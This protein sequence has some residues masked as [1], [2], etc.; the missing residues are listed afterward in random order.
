LARSTAHG[1][2]GLRA[3]RL[4]ALALIAAVVA[5]AGG[6]TAGA[7]TV[8][9]NVNVSKDGLDFGEAAVAVNPTNP[10]Q[11]FVSGTTGLYRYSTDGGSTWAT[12]STGPAPASDGGDTSLG[13]DT[14]GN[15]FLVILDRGVYTMP[16]TGHVL[17]FISTDGGNNF[18]QIATLGTGV[19]SGNIDQPSVAVGAGEV[20]VCWRGAD[21]KIQASGAN[22]TGS[23]SGSVGSFTAPE[24]A[25]SGNFGDIAIGPTGAVMVTY[26]R[27][28]SA[29]TAS[30][31][32][33]LD[34]DG[35][36]GG[37]FAG[38]I[39]VTD[40]FVLGFYPIPPQNAR[41]VDAEPNLAWD[42]SGGSHNGRVYLV[43]TNTP[44]AGSADTNIFVVFSDDNGT[45]WSSPVKANDDGGSN[46]Q[47]LPAIAIDQ[48]TGKIG[49]T[50]YDSRNDTGSGP[51]DTNGVAN[52]DAQYWGTTS[53]DG[54]GF[55]TNFQISAG[56]SN[57]AAAGSG[58]DYGDYSKVAY[59]DGF[60]Y[61]VWSDNSNSTGDNP[62]LTHHAFD[63]YIAVV[64]V[65][66]HA[67]SVAYSGATS[68]HFNDAATLS[69]TLTDTT[70]GAV[71]PGQTLKF[72]IGTQNCTGTTD[73][74]GVASCTITPN[75]HPG[76]YTVVVDYLGDSQHANSTQSTPFTIQK[77][78]T[79]LTY[80][81]A[82]TTHY[83]DTLNAS[84]TL[85]DPD[86]NTAIAGKTVTFTLGGTN[87]CSGTTDAFGVA[88]CP[89]TPTVTGS[90]SIVASF[91]GDLDYKSAD[92]T[93]TV[94]ITAEE[95]TMKYT[96]P[97]V[98]L[99][100]AAGATLTATLVEDGANDSDGDGGSAAPVPAQSVT[101]S[102]GSQ[103]CSG[104]TD[105]AGTAT[106]TIG[107]VSVPLG[108]EPVGASSTTNAYYQGSSDSTT[109][110]VFAF[111]ARG[112][113]T[114]GNVTAAG[115]GPSTKVSWWADTWP[116]LNA[117]GG[118]AAPSSFK[119]FAD[120]VTLPTTTPPV[121]CGSSWKSTGGNSP[122]PV[123]GIP[124]YMG[125]VVTSSVAKTGSTISGNSVHIVVVKVD[126]GYSPNPG[127]PGTGTIVGVFC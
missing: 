70:A 56:T 49:V 34:G 107:S 50:W 126:P 30:I 108:P 68:I 99:A 110:I 11:A 14:F 69:A 120:Q 93:K 117:L 118:G 66:K 16:K 119:G 1:R 25:G 53:D 113:F 41:T 111:P 4:A 26:Q 13:W 23:G 112:V 86:D 40:T 2:T 39:K 73:G 48:K 89:I 46:S 67:T 84:A 80:G 28:V 98:I 61:P 92:D 35:T 116:G 102:L 123:S 8:G 115:A 32:T 21:G 71:L 55:A 79:Q 37:G 77:E 60:M 106:C 81:G 122:P 44:S 104:T 57:A 74:S 94:S 64:V 103:H 63:T 114:L 43:Y 38:E 7:A 27:N 17:V 65:T 82:T 52:D 109:A 18:T 75:Q 47:F 87:T 58:I 20:W 90:Q 19:S 97:T 96:G 101:L 59:V 91:A 42:R 95:T 85:I 124:S 12:P 33:A 22:V 54:T 36:G 24:E 121:G 83:H 125:V 88:S 6:G 78:D 62:A 9:P 45:S 72:T 5:L 31:Y 100:G 105:S 29:T 3:S 15:L 127:H 76:P 10:Q 51:G